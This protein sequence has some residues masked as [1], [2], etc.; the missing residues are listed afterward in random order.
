MKRYY[1]TDRKSAG[2]LGAL[3]EIIRVQLHLGVEIIQIR[4]KDL[5]ARQLFEFT[6]AVL[7]ARQS[8]IS[9]PVSTKIMINTRADIALATGA[10]G[11]HLPAS[12][13]QDSLPGLL[14]ARSCHTP[15]EVRKARASFVTFGPVFETPGKGAAQGL[16]A[17]KAACQ[18]GKPVFALGGVTWDNAQDCIDV[19]A[20]GVAGIRLFQ[21][22]KL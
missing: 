19:G 21:N 22:L 6:L 18:Q 5:P 2:G 9:A 15:E 7:Q 3:L 17:L 16:A 8:Q 14:I 11:V 20:H 13:P 12:A 4:E 10:D 1:I